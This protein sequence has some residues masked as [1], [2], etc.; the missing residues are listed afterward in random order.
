MEKELWKFSDDSGSFVSENADKIKSL[1]FPLCNNHPFMSCVS[2]DLHGDAK[3]SFN[4]FLLE[5]VSRHSLSDSK[6]S[7]NFWLYLDSKKV[8]SAS[9]VSKDLALAKSD[10]FK[11]EAGLLWHKITRENQKIGLKAEI[12]S[13]APASAEPVEIMQ[14]RIT[15]TS[16]KTIDFTPTAAIPIYGRSANNLHDHRHVTSLLNRI[17]IIKNGVILTPTLKFNESG[18]E[19][20]STSYFILGI[21][22]NKSKPQYFYPTQE[23]FCGETSDLEA[24]KAI[25]EN[26]PP[27]ISLPINGREAFGGLKFKRRTLGPKKSCTYIILLGITNQQRDIAKIL[28]RFN[29]VEKINRARDLTEKFWLEKSS[30]ISTN[31]ADKNFDNW[32]RWVTVQPTLRR[33]FGCSFLPDFDY[34]KGGRGW[35]DLWQDCLS[36]ILTNPET[37]RNLLIN[38]F[39]GVRI[40]GSNATIIGQNPGE[41]IADRN[42]ISRV[43]M[44][45]AAWPLLTIQLYIDQTQDFKI[46]QERV[47][48]FRDLQLSRGKEKDHY[49]TPEYGKEL[50]TKNKKAYLGTVLEHLLVQNLV[51]FFNV[52]PHNHIRLENADWNDGLDMAGENGESVAFSAL[53]AQNLFSLCEILENLGTNNIS[54]FKELTML[55]DSLTGK[56]INYSDKDAKVARLNDYFRAVKS[57]ISGKT[58]LLPV[59]ALI[60]DLKMKADWITSHIRKTEWLKPGIYNGYYD[61]HKQRVEGIIKSNPQMTLTGQSFTIMSGVATDAQI[62][63][64]F[65]NA[66]KY[67]QSKKLGGFHLNTDFKNEQLG[68]GRAFSF[69]YGDKE[70]GAFFNHMA[71]MFAYGLYKRGLVKEGFEV[72]NSIYKMATDTRTSKIYPCLPEYFDTTGR[73]MYSYLT[74]SASWFI[75]T[76]LTQV[77]GI[78]GKYGDLII[79]PKLTSKQFGKNKEISLVTEFAKRRIEVKFINP[80]GKD[81]KEYAIT[82]VGLNGKIL[83]EKTNLALFRLK[84]K[85][86]LTLAKEKLNT[87]E[88]ILS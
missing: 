75:F 55:L 70:N 39:K 66:K 9:G 5:P 69:V 68:L 81:F 57:E 6:L 61:N 31:T 86:L 54:V 85:D 25:L 52:G 38:N 3:T 74:G 79:E 21:D 19:K 62:K 51:Q 77:F 72:I 83:L 58:T 10:K 82:Q 41:F 46:L 28:N 4:T 71:V 26:L 29:S 34:G 63:T 87:F 8:W 47:S 27:D 16:R 22:E 60:Q 76:M 1:Y 18:H 40:D 44:D 2:S 36:L 7:R 24:P 48:Y 78:R 43:W 33:I 14:V 30:E 53:Y 20:N 15:N 37:T 45:H 59:P 67:L 84:R 23:S 73:G 17:Q 12:T 88:I 32:L 35:R 64:I 13:F 11:L 56:K 65:K 42:N 50:K 80:R 49:W